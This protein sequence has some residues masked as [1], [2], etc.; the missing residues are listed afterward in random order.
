MSQRGDWLTELP[1]SYLR[2]V[3]EAMERVNE[4]PKL[5]KLLKEVK[6]ATEASG[7][8]FESTEVFKAA[9][10]NKMK[11]QKTIHEL[12][13]TLKELDRAKRESA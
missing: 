10:K 12:R 5:E 6:K 13:R 2:L 9:D 11:R 8:E 3:R 1:P 4:S 7:M